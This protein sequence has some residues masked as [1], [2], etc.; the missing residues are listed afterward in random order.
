MDKLQSSH[1][2]G[3]EWN[4]QYSFVYRDQYELGT[5]YRYDQYYTALP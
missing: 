3:S 2:F 5:N 1:W 4:G